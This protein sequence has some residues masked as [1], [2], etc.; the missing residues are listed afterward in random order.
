MIWCASHK[1]CFKTKII[2]V[3]L[4]NLVDFVWNRKI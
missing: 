2:N 4:H 1:K 3:V